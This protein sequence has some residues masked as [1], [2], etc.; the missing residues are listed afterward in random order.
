M[1]AYG[2]VDLFF[3]PTS[4]GMVNIAPVA[5]ALLGET[6]FNRIYK[7][8][9]EMIIRN[10]QRADLNGLPHPQVM[11]SILDVVNSLVTGCSSC[12]ARAS[13]M[14]VSRK[15]RILSKVCW[16]NIGF[17]LPPSCV[18]ARHGSRVLDLG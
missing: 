9:V 4:G 11:D 15:L 7:C 18:V 8:R 10:E 13:A 16:V 17:D 3:E 14:P 6:F 2:P 12:R 1:Q 5:H